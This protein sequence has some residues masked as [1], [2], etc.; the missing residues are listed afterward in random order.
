MKLTVEQTQLLHEC[1]DLALEV[2]AGL[3]S[4]HEVQISLC[5]LRVSFIFNSMWNACYGGKDIEYI[6]NLDNNDTHQLQQAKDYL[7]E[8]LEK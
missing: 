8:L 4:D 6:V 7:T 1:L 3:H 5:R 2:N